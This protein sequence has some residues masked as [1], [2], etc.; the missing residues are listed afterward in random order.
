MACIPHARGEL[1]GIAS[2]EMTNE[3]QR[4]VF[5]EYVNYITHLME[6]LQRIQTELQEQVRTWRLSP[7]VDALQALRGVQFHTAVTIVAELGDITRFDKPQ[8]LMAFV[9]LHPSEHSSGSTRR[10]GASP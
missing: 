9:G 10:Q 7:V 5:R 3:A 8:Q 1:G 2:G 6:L 4:I